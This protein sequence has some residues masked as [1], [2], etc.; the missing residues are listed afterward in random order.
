MDANT[1]WMISGTSKKITNMAPY[2]PYLSP[3]CFKTYKENYE[4]I[5]TYYFAYLNLLENPKKSE[6]L[7]LPD[8]NMEELILFQNMVGPKQLAS[9]SVL[10][11]IFGGGILINFG[12]LKIT[13]I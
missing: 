10:K 8:I 12:N 5:L 6:L 13:E 11:D 3:T 4:L 2:T 7:T 9:P 1:F